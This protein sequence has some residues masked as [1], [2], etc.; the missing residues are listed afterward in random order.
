MVMSKLVG[1]AVDFAIMQD[2][3]TTID[4]ALKLSRT[5]QSELLAHMDAWKLTGKLDDFN[6]SPYF[7]FF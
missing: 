2:A 6:I 1:E 5:L 4:S 3:N 7:R